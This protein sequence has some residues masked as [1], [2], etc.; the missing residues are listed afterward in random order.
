M[1]DTAILATAL[2]RIVHVCRSRGGTDASTGDRLTEKQLRTLSHLDVDD[3]TMVT[4]LAEFLGVTAS[5]MSLNLTRLE[6]GGYV[7]RARDP[8]DRRAMNVRLTERGRAMLDG[9]H[10]FDPERI[11]ALLMHVRPED[12]R[13]ALDGIAILAEAADAAVTTGGT[14]LAGLVGE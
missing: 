2:P 10:P 8:H 14:Q 5:T 11:S 3:P 9:H 13:R 7:S 4:E 6:A 1:S 12:R